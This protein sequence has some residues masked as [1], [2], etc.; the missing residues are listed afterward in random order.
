M[1]TFIGIHIFNGYF[2]DPFHT[3]V[4]NFTKLAAKIYSL[5]S[6]LLIL[7]YISLLIYKDRLNIILNV[8]KTCN[9][10]VGRLVNCN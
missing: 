6:F 8:L 2:S 10:D 4:I 3:R 9:S 1:W 5:F 7:F